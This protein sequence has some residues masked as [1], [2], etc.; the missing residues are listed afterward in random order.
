MRTDKS[1][2]PGN[3]C[4][5]PPEGKTVNSSTRRMTSSDVDVSTPSRRRRSP[6]GA[7]W[8]LL[9]V[10]FLAAL[11]RFCVLD[12][13]PPG[14]RDDELIEI[15]MDTR[16]QEGWRPL[17]IREAEGHE[18][19]FHYLH[20]GTLALFGHNAFGYRWLPAAF[21]LL[22]TALIVTLVWRLFGFRVA[23]LAGGLYAVGLWPVLY[24]RFGVRHIGVMP[25]ILLALY[26][27]TRSSNLVPRSLKE[28][29]LQ[30]SLG[31]WSW[32][33]GASM[34][35]GLYVYY[36]AW[37]M[38]VLVV[39][40][41]AYLMVFDR[42]RFRQSWPALVLALVVAGLI[43]FPLGWDLAHGPAVTRITVTGAPLRALFNGDPLPVIQTTLGTLGMFTFSGDP[44]WLYNFS[45]LPV[46]DWII[47]V[48][49]YLGLVIC[50]LRVRQARYGFVLAWIVVGIS[51]AFISV[52]P[53]SYSHT[54][55]AQGA[56]YLM[57][58]IGLIELSNLKLQTL[59]LVLR[60]GAFG[61]AGVSNL[62]SRLPHLKFET[63]NLILA[64]AIAWTARYTLHYYFDWWAN[65][66]MVRFQYHA[67]THDL[68]RWLDAQPEGGGLAISTTTN[69][70]PLEPLALAFDLK[71][72]DIAPR[73]FDAEWA[74]VFP[75]GGASRIA[76]L[77]FPHLNPLLESYLPSQ[78]I[79]EHRNPPTGQLAFRVYQDSTAPGSH[80][81]VPGGAPI[82]GARLTLVDAVLPVAP[83]PG[84]EGWLVTTWRV[85]G[86]LTGP[87]QVFAHLLDAGG[88]MIGGDDRL[89]VLVESL[90]VGDVFLQL[91]RLPRPAQANCAPCRIRLGVYN[92]ETGERLLT[93]A[94]DSTLL[95]VEVSP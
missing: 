29:T 79:A 83:R 39:V 25:F 45:S 33:L 32:V 54:F 28:P 34:G 74:L 67:D 24:S 62:K 86:A 77:S 8:V 18:P 60:S 95:P 88:Q 14:W 76:L 80:G 61:S 36:A 90:R 92:P 35:L 3:L 37:V 55:A 10:L 66:A 41:G 26:A 84:G 5:N 70:F 9:A 85:D 64:L 71:R 7:W 73:W 91:N 30:A 22:S 87:L 19:L 56:A 78:L 65:H 48:L 52:P 93:A 42:R 82:F 94:G 63:R 57:P 59:A 17:Y 2:L 23:A 38:P 44:E 50:L 31:I 58:A 46:F 6:P 15:G 69:E 68:A 12:R 21:G 51:P 40:F 75:H 13:V 11:A 49:F 47:G 72:E 4:Y 43:F 20:A 81:V 16:I 27:L 89:S 53:A 1:C